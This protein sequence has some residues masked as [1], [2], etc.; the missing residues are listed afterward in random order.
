MSTSKKTW[1]NTLYI[2]LLLVAVFLLFRWYSV[3]N[4]RQIETQNRNYAMDSARQTVLGLS[5]EFTNAERRARNY[6]FFLSVGVDTPEINARMLSQLEENTDFDALRFVD[7]EGVNLTSDGTTSDSA[8]RDY[9]I[10]GMKGESGTSMVLNS[11]VTNKTTMVFYAPVLENGEV[12]GV[13]LGLYYAE[14]YLKEILET[15][16]FGEKADV[17]LCTR[18]GEVIASSGGDRKDKAILDVLRE[19]GVIDDATAEGA[20]KVF[21]GETDEEG[22]ICKAG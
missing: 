15:S 19:T 6:A 17:Y 10:E 1:Q 3:S 22:F 7:T 12:D 5:N 21:R 14:D 11:R 13:L 2:F 9:F 18:E 8:D 16:Y 20:W 4:K